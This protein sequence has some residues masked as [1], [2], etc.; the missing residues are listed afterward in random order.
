MKTTNPKTNLKYKEWL[1]ADEMHH[2][3][4]EWLSELEFVRDEHLFFKNL[5]S[6]F[7]LQLI[8]KKNFAE[9]KKLIKKLNI[10]ILE[11]EELFNLIK[12]HENNLEIIIDEINQIEKETAYKTEHLELR[13]SI[14]KFLENYKELKVR[15]FNIIKDIKKT[16]KQKYLI[17]S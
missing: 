15:L 11:N 1:S 3:S 14:K 7:T 10:S 5:I 8:D 13:F 12:N 9:S 4:K 2:N 16:E 17:E 6:S